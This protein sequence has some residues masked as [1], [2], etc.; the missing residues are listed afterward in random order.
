MQ[1]KYIQQ[2]NIIIIEEIFRHKSDISRLK[3]KFIATPPSEEFSAQNGM[4]AGTRKEYQS[5]D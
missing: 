4:P 1:H 5:T 2:F 3:P